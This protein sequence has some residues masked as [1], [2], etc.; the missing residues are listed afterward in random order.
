MQKT[1]TA[2]ILKLAALAAAVSV[3]G[4]AMAQTASTPATAPAVQQSSSATP[5]VKRD[6]H[7]HK[8][9]KRMGHHAGHHQHHRA[10]M[11]VP[12]YGPLG[13]KSVEALKLN[14]DQNKLLQEARDAQK[15]ER[16]QRFE[17]MKEKREARLE[18]LKAGKLDPRA[19]LKDADKAREAVSERHEKISEKWLALWDSLDD[20]QQK[21]VAQQFTQR[22]E[23]RSERMKQ[24]AERRA[25]KE[26]ATDKGQAADKAQVKS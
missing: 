19:A 17:G 15:A 11:L 6:G 14:E 3:Q 9:H 7:H 2:L 5:D 26:Q 25:Q 13:E 24:H 23:Q 12:G 8:H 18:T 10:A 16:E 1:N 20:G 22:A 21:L 4:V